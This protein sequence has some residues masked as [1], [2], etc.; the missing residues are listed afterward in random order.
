MKPLDV[1]F[2]ENP[3]GRCVPA[4]VGMVLGYFYPEHS[5]SLAE[6]SEVCGYQPGR[7][8]W[9]I[10]PMLTLANLGLKTKWIED[11]DHA[12]FIKNP[13]EYLASILDEKSYQ[14]QI[15]HGDVEANAEL[16]KQYLQNH[17]IEKR[18]ATRQDI[19]Q[20]LQGGWLVCLE[21]N[22]NTLADK[23]GYEGHWVVV[24]GYDDQNV[25]LH[26]PDGAN[27]NQPNQIVPW[28]KLEKAWREFG[29]SFSLYAF[30]K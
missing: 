7:A 6:L 11:F 4:S 3:D 13:K 8:T 5:Y 27:G 2:V 29:G 24:I 14:W 23:P 25:T 30:K 9:S 17:Q 12:A 19:Q 26:N 20:L 1:P 15:K 16:L 10:T 18:P 28:P 22:A 21:V